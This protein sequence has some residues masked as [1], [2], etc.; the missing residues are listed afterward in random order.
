ME[1]AKNVSIV[2]LSLCVICVMFLSSIGHAASPVTATESIKETIDQVLAVLRNEELKGADKKDERL[3]QLTE[4]IG[5][6]FDYEEMGKRTL[7]RE[8][9]NL[10]PEQQEEFV[11]LFQRFLTKSYAG[12]VD[13]YSGETIE[14]IK[15]RNK[16][17][18]A[19]VQTKVVSLKSQVPLD[20]RLLKK[21]E[22]WRIYDVVID[23][24]SLM[25]NYRGQFDRILKTSS[26][27]G[28]LTKL[29]AKADQAQP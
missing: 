8:W 3:T 28:L 15:E 20:Y 29:R 24:V 22:E 12:N 18:F 11:G 5:Q 9:K 13:S 26:F 19:E 23:G 25:K 2:V 21:N 6:R 14:Y 7:S 10:T 17:D 1:S 27:E 4:I 16:G